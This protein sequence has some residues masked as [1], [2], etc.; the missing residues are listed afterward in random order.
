MKSHNLPKPIFLVLFLLSFIA[1]LA[2]SGCGESTPVASSSEVAVVFVTV[3][4]SSIETPTRMSV[5]TATPISMAAPTHTLA[6]TS[7]PISS[8]TPTHPPTAEPIIN[9][10]DVK[11]E[12]GLY[13]TVGGFDPDTCGENVNYAT[14]TLV[15][16]TLSS[17]VVQ[18]GGFPPAVC[19]CGYREDEALVVT[20]IDPSGQTIYSDSATP[21]IHSGSCYKALEIQ[22]LDFLP[23]DPLGQYTVKISSQ[24]NDIR[25]TFELIN[26]TEPI[27]YEVYRERRFAVA[28]FK[29]FEEVQ[30]LEYIVN[31][32]SETAELA[33]DRML[34]LDQNGRAS[35]INDHSEES[36]IVFVV[37]DDLSF[38]SKVPILV[39]TDLD[40]STLKSFPLD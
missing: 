17:T 2:V 20:V 7:A 40:F 25:Y 1:T 33:Q 37:R 5:F 13:F 35:W 6:P 19:V 18:L 11:R 10:S 8:D 15:Q 28:G 3:T 26:A 32:E 4:P 29:S 12:L 9:P 14:P 24:D 39:E 27:I 38:V 36:V 16:E 30:I 23:S 22:Y 21:W 34:K 31:Y